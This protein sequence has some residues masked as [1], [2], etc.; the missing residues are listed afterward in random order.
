MLCNTLVMMV[1]AR[2]EGNF[3]IAGEDGGR[4]AA[5]HALAG[6]D[7]VGSA[8]HQPVGIGHAGFGREVVH[9]IVQQEARAGHYHF[10]AVGTIQGRGAAHGVAEGIDDAV[11]R[12]FGAF[13]ARQLGPG[14][15]AGAGRSPAPRAERGGA[16]AVVVHI[17]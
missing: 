16:L 7:G 9:L 11:V 1:R 5:E 12:G 13:I 6:R 3:T 17:E 2:Y 15:Y 14:G 8:A 4:H 10:A